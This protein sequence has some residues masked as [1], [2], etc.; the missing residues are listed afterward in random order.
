M[1]GLIEA[2]PF[3]RGAVGRTGTLAVY[4]FSEGVMSARSPAILATYPTP[5]ILGTFG[6][7]A[8]ELEGAIGRMDRE[9]TIGAGDGTI[10]LRSGRI[11]STLDLLAYE[12]QPDFEPEEWLDIPDGFIDS[13]RAALPFV[14][15]E[16]HWQRS[17]LL[18]R[19]RVTAI[20]GKS[21]VEVEVSGLDVEGIVLPYDCLSYL[22][23][24]DALP[25]KWLPTKLAVTFAWEIGARAKCQTLAIPWPESYSSSSFF[26]GFEE[27]AATVDSIPVDDNY[28]SAFA[29]VAVVANLSDGVATVSPS[30]ILGKSSH[31][32]QEVELPT[33]VKR[34]TKW[35]IKTLSPVLAVASEWH[36]DA[37]G[38]AFFRGPGVRGIVLGRRE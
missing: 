36:P 3:L 6:I 9:P 15:T 24:L 37:D 7:A 10:I 23:D 34:A 28:R 19:G 32:T 26:D 20:N 31:G 30:G 18:D 1:P 17:L 16:G 8:D 25:S 2:V 13:I 29:D 22:C 5:H 4:G 27:K 14:A 38:P 11:R 35:S 12:P 21:A 33:R